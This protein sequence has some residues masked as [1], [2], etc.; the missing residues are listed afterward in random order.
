MVAEAEAA[1]ASDTHTPLDAANN[2]PAHNTDAPDNTAVK[3]FHIP[4]EDG[5]FS[6][7]YL[8]TQS[9]INLSLSSANQ[10]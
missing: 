3:G 5:Y 8:S 2:T 6:A 7:A 4:E 9:R 10:Q 1:A